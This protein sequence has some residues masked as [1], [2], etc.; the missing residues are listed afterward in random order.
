M[1]RLDAASIS[2]RSRAR[3]SRMALHAWQASQGSALA[4]EVLAVE[5]LGE[6]PRERR[7][8]GATRSGEQDRV[9]HR[10]VGRR[11][12]AWRRPPPGRRSRRTSGRAIGGRGPGGES[13][14]STTLLRRAR[15]RAKCRA[16]S[17]D[18]DAPAPSGERDSDQAVPRHPAISAEC[19]FL[20]DLTR[21]T[22]HRCAGPGPQR[23]VRR[24][25]SRSADLGR[26]FSP[27]G[28]D[29][30]YRAPLVP[31]LAR[32]GDDSR[33]PGSG[34]PRGRGHDRPRDREWLAERAGFEPAMGCPI[35]HFQCGA[36]GH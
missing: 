15:P 11:C 17:V 12:A 34:R 35:P 33:G 14:L 19:C 3:P 2:T 6:D 10:P 28:A 4:R 30:R 27:A 1:P 16:P 23:R 21:F 8:A 9:R 5:R 29:C 24:R 7:L 13:L 26:E 20:P 22:S 31:R 36:L 32:P 18:P 25:L